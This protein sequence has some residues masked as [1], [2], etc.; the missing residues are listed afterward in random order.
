[1]SRIQSIENALSSINETIFQ[2]LCDSFLILRNKNYSAFSRTG[3]QLG[4]QKTIKGTPDTFLLLPNGKYIFVEY[5]TNITAGVSKLEDDIRKCIDSSKTGVPI[6]HIAEIILCINFKLKVDEIDRL[7]KLSSKARIHLTIFTLDDLV[8]QINLQHRD[9]AHLYLQ[10]PL[11]TGQIV[12]VR[13]FI[14][15]YN[16]A[17][18][19]IATP[20]SN[21][22]LHREKEQLEL[23]DALVLDDFIILTG[24]PGVGKTKLALETISKFVNENPEFDAYCISYKSHTLLDDLHQHLKQENNYI[25]FVDDA[26]RVDAFNQVLG[27][28]KGIRTGKLKIILTVRDYA[29]QEIDILAHPFS[30]TRIDISKLTDEQ[31]IDIIKGKP[32]EILNPIYHPEIVRIADGNPRLA[33]MAALLAKE[34]QDISALADVSNLFETYFSTFITDKNDFS[35]N[36]NIKCLGIISFF[37]TIPYKNKDVAQAILEKFEITYN[38]FINTIDKLDQLE[39]V[40]LQF[41]HVKIPEQNLATYFFYKAFIKDGLLRFD[42]LL[43]NYFE[44]NTNRFR[45]CVIPANNTFG[46]DNVMLKLQP[47]LQKHWNLIKNN[48]KKVF[49]FL[50]SFWFYLQQEAL[51]YVYN[52]TQSLTYELV[53]SYKVSYEMNEF[54]Y[55]HNEVIELLGRFFRFPNQNLSDAIEL[56]FEYVRKLP[57]HLPELI[58]KIREV[59]I[60]DREDARTGFMRQDTLYNILYKGLQ[61]H[62]PLIPVSFYELSKTFLNFQFRQTQSGR[63]HSVVF[64]HY[65]IP[66]HEIIHLFREKIWNAVKIHFDDYPELSINLLANYAK[67]QPDVS[68]AI[69]ESDMPYV[70]DIIEQKLSNSDFEHC[71]Y[72]QKQIRWW[73]R[74][75]IN[76][77][78]FDTLSKKFTNAVYEMYTVLDWDRIRD[79]EIFDFENYKEYDKL[80]EEQIRSSFVINDQN[81]IENFFKNYVFIKGISNNEWSFRNTL[82]LIVDENCARDFNLGCN[83]LAEIIINNNPTDMIPNITFRNL[84]NTGNNAKAIW[85]IIQQQDF[86]CKEEWEL[87][88]YN[89]LSDSL[90]NNDFMNAAISTIQKLQGFHSIHFDGLKKFLVIEPTLFKIL[91]EIIYAK[92]EKEGTRLSIWIDF[93]RENFDDL[94]DDIDLLKKVYIQQDIIQQ[95]FD[96][97]GEGLLKIL[98]YDKSFLLDYVKSL[99]INNDFNVSSR[100]EDLSII[101]KVNNI[102]KDL[103]HVL[104]FAVDNTRYS[105]RDHFSNSFFKLIPLDQ[106]ERG[107]AFLLDYTKTNYSN[108]KKMNMIVDIVRTSMRIMFDEFLLYFISLTQ[109][110]E[111]FGNLQWRGNGGVYSGDVIIGDIQASEW[112]SIL[113]TIEKSPFGFKLIPIKKYINDQ[114]ESSLRYGD[115]ERQQRFIERY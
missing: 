30:P 106:F 68:K 37:Y 45:D 21:A 97:Y 109:D 44:S 72:V 93:F 19:G 114:I 16:K 110:V 108:I 64:Y 112:K 81:E 50:D 63:N 77:P 55:D 90:V 42:T 69:M 51:E 1:M 101:W 78:A 115:W 47:Y 80:K 15:E 67:T 10:L 48:E 102:E 82:D 29:F 92:N 7:K 91:L 66:N 107:K 26:N 33:I 38:E 17:S 52:I 59:L 104:D 4:K 103:V 13:T 71:K 95:H 84:L 25:L 28:Y 57:V 100:T 65:P 18:K 99:L 46:Y 98:N 8:L 43:E 87:C 61:S 105:L 53:D 86:H 113:S 23:K 62:N 20:L 24:M 27:F 96:F 6:S 35:S 2:E 58:H 85:N 31:I 70:I 9:L 54:T 39:L 11:D 3:S 73:K 74:N 79:K 41:D 83:L 94:V 40:E 32:F 49:K 12:T 36:S 75:E 89:N 5:S 88:F 34:K 76:N 14:E 22:F 60:F 111:L 56:S